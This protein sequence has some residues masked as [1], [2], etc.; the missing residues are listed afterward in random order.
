MSWLKYIS[1]LILVAILSALL[2]AGITLWQMQISRERAVERAV[3][4]ERERSNQEIE[5]LKAK[6]K[7]AEA[8]IERLKQSK[9]AKESAR[10]AVEDFFKNLQEKDFEAAYRLLAREIEA[11]AFGR[12]SER[13]VVAAPN[14]DDF[15]EE[16]K[17]LIP[18]F[19]TVSISETGKSQ[20]WLK[21]FKVKLENSQA[22]EVTVFKN[23]HGSWKISYEF[24][25]I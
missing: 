14:F 9:V 6:L 10:K 20:P 19:E 4:A 3:E 5:K 2:T 1:S 12:F 17:E 11:V 16:I 15:K 21:T 8:E 23:V 25:L 18:T 7:D 13:K 24:K 22:V